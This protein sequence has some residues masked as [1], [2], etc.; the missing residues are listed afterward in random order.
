MS[1]FVED[2]VD[3]FMPLDGVV[4]RYGE[5][6]FDCSFFYSA[7]Y[8]RGRFALALRLGALG[9]VAKGDEVLVGWYRGGEYVRAD[10]VV[11]ER[12]SEFLIP[13]EDGVSGG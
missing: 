2:V 4:P 6:G 7:E 10:G 5:P 1:D 13:G 9:E 12:P 3:S 11:V 8:N